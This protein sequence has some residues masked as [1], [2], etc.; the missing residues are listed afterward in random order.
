MGFI[1]ADCVVRS[2]I[3]SKV[4]EE[5]AE[6]FDAMG[7]NLSEA[8]R[9][10]LYQAVAEKCIP[11]SI[12]LPNAKTKATLEQ[13]NKKEKLHKTSLKQLSDDWDNA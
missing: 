1:M 11:F 3:D 2:R 5:A 12:N 7:L 10:F 4:K 8:I 13:V 6:L 9:L